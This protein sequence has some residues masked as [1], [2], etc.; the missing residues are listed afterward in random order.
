MAFLK[1]KEESSKF[2]IQT[3]QHIYFIPSLFIHAKG[4]VDAL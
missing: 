4:T 1:Q 3:K 2:E